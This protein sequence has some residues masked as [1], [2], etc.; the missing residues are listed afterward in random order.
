LLAF[1]WENIE[2]SVLEFEEN[3]CTIRE[4]SI[5]ESWIQQKSTLG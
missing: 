5:F 3:N 1:I 4:I 2:Y